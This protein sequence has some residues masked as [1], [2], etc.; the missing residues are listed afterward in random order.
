MSDSWLRVRVER[1]HQEALNI[2][3]MDLVTEDGR[4]LPAFTAGAHIDVEVSPGMIRQYSLC[5]D[6]R[7][8]YRYRIAVLREQA[9]RGGSQAL[10]ERVNEGESL[11]IG[12]PRNHFPLVTGARHT[13][14]VA[15]GI[16]ITPILSMTE[17]LS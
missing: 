9:S 10:C 15:A 6:T 14:L 2:F 3:S 11:R 13:V 5:G 17:E 16:G 12:K 1:K 8:S 7:D 4:A